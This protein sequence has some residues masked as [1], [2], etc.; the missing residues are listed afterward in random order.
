MRTRNDEC[1]ARHVAKLVFPLRVCTGAVISEQLCSE[2]A[3]VPQIDT[4]IW[5][6]SA[7]PAVYTAGDF[8]LVPRGSVFGIMEIK[9]SLYSGVG[10]QLTEAATK[11]PPL[12]RLIL[13][14]PATKGTSPKQSAVKAV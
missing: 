13:K 7:L 3:K 1:L 9:R 8:G 2:P 6:P 12:K 5:S 4:I 10:K 14:I 11:Q